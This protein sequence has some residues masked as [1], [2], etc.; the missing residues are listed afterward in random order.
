[1]LNE[2]YSHIAAGCLISAVCVAGLGAVY[3]YFSFGVFSFYMIYAFAFFLIG[4]TVFWMF[5]AKMNRETST[6][7]VCFW[8]AALATFTAGSLLHGVLDIYGTSSPLIVIFWIAG[9]LDI[10]AAFL[11]EA[12]GSLTPQ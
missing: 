2:R 11:T 12:L 1:M 4:G 5:L 7:F 3:E 6:L 9:L 8:N 10:A